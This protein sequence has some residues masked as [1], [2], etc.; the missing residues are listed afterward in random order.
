MGRQ[1]TLTD[2]DY[3]ALAAAAART[4]A[5]IEE[6]VH[7]AIADKLPIPKQIGSYQYPTGESITDEEEAE[8]ERLAQKIGSEHPWASE[9]VIEDRGPR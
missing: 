6:L 2:E 4:G 7:Q 8:M 9:I 1:I 3:T 5:T